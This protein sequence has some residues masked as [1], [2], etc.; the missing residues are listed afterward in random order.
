[1]NKDIIQGQWKE[2]KGKLQQQWGKLTDD[3]ISQLKGSY[4]ELEGLLQKRYGYKR[5][6]VEKEIELF[7][8]KNKI[9]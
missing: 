6:E 3:E 2:L 7:V 9:H 5:D 8:D 4:D 1:M